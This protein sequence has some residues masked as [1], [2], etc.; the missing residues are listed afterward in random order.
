M[1]KLIILVGLPRSGKSS[2]A[3]K[4]GYP[5]VNLDLIRLAMHGHIFLPDM[6]EFVWAYAKTLIKLEFLRE[7][8]LV[9]L[10]ATN[11]RRSRRNY[12][13]GQWQREFIVFN[14]K[15]EVCIERAKTDNRP[16][17]IA[18]IERMHRNFEFPTE[19]EGIVVDA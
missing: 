7:A 3:K 15:M 19:D 6:E 12:W 4:L 10:D 5:I 9:V 1:N 16:E 8:E 14:T 13:Y 11:T 2:F 17:L 18:V